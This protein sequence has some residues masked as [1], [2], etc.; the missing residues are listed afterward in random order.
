MRIILRA[1]P[2][3]TVPQARSGTTVT[4]GKHLRRGVA[5]GAGAVAGGGLGH[6]D[7]PSASPSKKYAE[8]QCQHFLFHLDRPLFNFSDRFRIQMVGVIVPTSLRSS[9][10]AGYLG[11]PSLE[12]A[13]RSSFFIICFLFYTVRKFFQVSP[14]EWGSPHFL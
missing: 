7:I 14:K 2:V 8:N 9:A 12:L 1:K 4:G 5:S 13:C 3:W 10:L 11:T 6:P